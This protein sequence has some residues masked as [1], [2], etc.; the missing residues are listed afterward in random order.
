MARGCVAG[1]INNRRMTAGKHEFSVRSGVFRLLGSAD[2]VALPYGYSSER[3]SSLQL[4]PRRNS[5]A[6]H[7][8][9][10]C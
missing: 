10:C 8:R 7:G 1:G 4:L 5:P 2:A 3:Q 6:R 9:R